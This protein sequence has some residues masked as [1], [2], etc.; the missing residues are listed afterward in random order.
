MKKTFYILLFFLIFSNSNS[1]TKVNNYKEQIEIQTINKK[2]DS[3]INSERKTKILEERINQATETISNQNS[4][5]SGFG[6]LYTIITIVFAIIGIALPILT[7]QFGI[8]PSQKALEEF[9]KNAEKKFMN[10]MNSKKQEE[11]DN[12]ILNLNNE[13]IFIKNN[14]LNY[15][16]LNYHLGFNETQIIKLIKFIEKNIGDDTFNMQ[17]AHCLTNQKNDDTKDFFINYLRNSTKIDNLIYYCMK[18]LSFYDYND[19]KDSFKKYVSELSGSFSVILN[20]TSLFS[21]ET[22]KKIMNDKEVIDKLK[23]EDFA[24]LKSSWNHHLDSWKM[25]ENEFKKTY[26]FQKI[27][28]LK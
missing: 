13:D 7:Y 17:L 1:Q 28:N 6:T 19:Y 15:L 21:R 2:I 4:M 16:S 22:T 11:I 24:Y 5:I 10:F 12:A 25:N 8:K 18:F 20:Y 9:D 23:P 26:L 14:A 3:I 27:E